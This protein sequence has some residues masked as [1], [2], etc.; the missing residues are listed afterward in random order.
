M[1]RSDSVAAVRR[2]RRSRATRAKTALKKAP[3]SAWFGI[4][5]I[6]GYVFVAV[7]AHWI[8]P[9][10]ETQVF[11]EAFAPWSQEFKLGT[12]QLGRDMLTR[13]IYG[14]RNTIAIAVATTL[15]SFAVGVSLGLLAALYRGWLDQILSR[16]VDVLMSIPSL[17]F[18]L[19]LLTI[20]GSSITSLIVIIALLDSTRVFRLSRAVGLNVAVMEYVEVARLRGE[21]PKWIIAKEILPNVM[22]PLV[23]EFGLRFCFVFLTV[24]ALSFLGVGIQPP[25]ADWGSMVRENATLITYGDVTPL[26]PAGAIALLTVSV[27]FV[28]DWFLQA[29][30]GLRD[31]K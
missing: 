4:V 19:V 29:T 26:L 16:A 13:L 6:L 31:E 11:S 2:L 14:A 27:N 10:G 15:L 18:A 3:F 30:S 9:Y 8:A 20:F 23:A 24:A 17:I 28:V 21:G 22:P 1:T 25:T 7:F 5:V 12:D